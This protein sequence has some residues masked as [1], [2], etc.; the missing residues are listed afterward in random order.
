MQPSA[1]GPVLAP[2]EP[3]GASANVNAT[4]ARFSPHRQAWNPWSPW[5]S[6][7]WPLGCPPWRRLARGL[8]FGWLELSAARPAGGGGGGVWASLAGPGIPS[9]ESGCTAFVSSSSHSAS[10]PR[11]QDR[12]C[13]GIVSRFD[14]RHPSRGGLA[15]CC[16]GHHHSRSPPFVKQSPS[17]PQHRS[18]VPPPTLVRARQ[19][20]DVP[21]R[22]R[23][24]TRLN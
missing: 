6:L 11:Q 17:T 24:G 22:D 12:I 15:F 14:R 10:P 9:L 5:K 2:L 19:H 7:G 1:Q 13:T 21:E 23:V 4:A 3:V 16:F 18:P 8:E 20:R